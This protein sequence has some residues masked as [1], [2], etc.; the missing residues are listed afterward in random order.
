MGSE[1]GA[2]NGPSPQAICTSPALDRKLEGGAFP[3]RV[4][5]VLRSTWAQAGAS[6][7][8]RGPS[9]R[10]LCGAWVMLSEPLAAQG[11]RAGLCSQTSAHVPGPNP[12]HSVTR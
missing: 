11:V 12:C 6:T 7:G 5:W 2:G 1:M 3:Q 10:R 9:C 4:T 8:T